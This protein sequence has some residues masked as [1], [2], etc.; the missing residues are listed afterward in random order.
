MT[1]WR[2]AIPRRPAR[3]Q[4]IAVVVWA[5]VVL[6]APPAIHAQVTGEMP[7]P[8]ALG[9]SI[10]SKPSVPQSR[11]PVLR[12]L[13]T[14]YRD[15]SFDFCR[16]KEDYREGGFQGMLE[17]QFGPIQDVIVDV[18]VGRGLHPTIGTIVPESGVAFGLALNNEWH[19]TEAPHS[20][21]T[22][23]VEARGSATG[24]W[25]AGAVSHMQIDW[26]RAHDVGSF[27]MPQLT[28]AVR[29]FDLPKMPFIRPAASPA[30]SRIRR[31]RASGRARCTWCRESPRPIAPRTCSTA[32]T[33]RAA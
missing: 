8:D 19:L 1:G 11:N 4:T 10:C 9:F 14:E 15:L 23:S 12:D 21:L 22:T 20:R 6:A 29:H 13:L 2:N 24:F 26:Y 33:A 32:F 3:R 27:R 7:T 31:R 25:A 5:L 28:A 17:R 18:F 30:G 16:V